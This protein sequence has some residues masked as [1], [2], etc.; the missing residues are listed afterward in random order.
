MLQIFSNRKESLSVGMTLLQV[1]VPLASAFHSHSTHPCLNP[2]Q[3]DK[4]KLQP[5][6]SNRE[7]FPQNRKLKIAFKAKKS[8]QAKSQTQAYL[9]RRICYRKRELKWID[10]AEGSSDWKE[11]KPASRTDASAKT[12]Q[13]QTKQNYNSTYISRQTGITDYPKMKILTFTDTYVFQIYNTLY[14]F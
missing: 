13:M 4:R 1:C 3:K 10:A 7:T 9:Q 11:E 6:V 14:I 2:L 8:S 5:V 12:P